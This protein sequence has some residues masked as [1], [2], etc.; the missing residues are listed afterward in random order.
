MRGD[1][2]GGGGMMDGGGDALGIPTCTCSMHTRGR[3]GGSA[4]L[5]RAAA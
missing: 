3:G 4:S 2:G 5:W 1:R